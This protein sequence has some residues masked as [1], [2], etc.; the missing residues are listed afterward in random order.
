M[1]KIAILTRVI[2]TKAVGTV[3]DFAQSFFGLRNLLQVYP[4]A[5]KKFTGVTTG[6]QATGNFSPG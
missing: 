6:R 3:L 5:E 4:V 2:A 1:H